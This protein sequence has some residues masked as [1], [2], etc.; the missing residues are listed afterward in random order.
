MDSKVKVIKDWLEQGIRL[1]GFLGGSGCVFMR[2]LL[3]C[4]SIYNIMCGVRNI[5]IAS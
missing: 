4:A 2:N 5:Y 1:M 3:G